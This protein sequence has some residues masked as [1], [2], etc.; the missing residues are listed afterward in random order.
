MADPNISWQVR[1]QEDLWFLVPSF[2]AMK[3]ITGVTYTYIL[4]IEHEN[5]KQKWDM[6]DS[7]S[8]EY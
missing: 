5:Y 6:D 3:I 7:N 1:Q 8:M 4:T 2:K